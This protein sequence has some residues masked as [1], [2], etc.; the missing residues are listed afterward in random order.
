MSRE[1]IA[2]LRGI[3]PPEAAAVTEALIAAGITKIEVPLNSPE[4]F[5]S[6]KAMLDGFGT[7]ATI[8]AGTVLAPEEVLRLAQIG[9]HMIVSPDCNQRVIMA[10]KKAGLLSYPGIMTPT[11]AFT[12]LRT[13][14][15]GIK[16]FP[17]SLI[18]P[19][20]LKAIGAVL[21]KGTRTYAV[22]GVA[23]ANFAEW[24]AAGATGFGIGTA[25][26][27]P[28]RSAADIA[29]RARDMVAAYDEG[30]PK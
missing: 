27:A 8:G 1:I 3:T 13:G 10:T 23:A 20:G 5:V 14:A 26:Y 19:A 4:P 30:A 2:I 17:G 11:E 12:A 16:L 9:A 7:Q 21:P 24:F 22:G 6:I 25:L 15:D 18:G 28:G 29:A